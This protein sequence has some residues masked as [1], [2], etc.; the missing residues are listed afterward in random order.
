MPTVI[1]YLDDPDYARR[2]LCAATPDGDAGVAPGHGPIHWVLVA[3][4]PRMTHRISKWVSHSAREKWRDR[5]ADKVFSAT[6][7]WLAGADDRVTALVARG[8]LPEL[9]RHLQADHPGAHLVDARRPKAGV[10]LKPL[11]APVPAPAPTATRRPAGRGA[12]W[13]PGTAIGLFA[14]AMN[15]AIE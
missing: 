9:L 15:L 11:Q 2:Q 12:R 6:T 7:P 4:A 14:M 13:M 5:W 10:A 3:C 8:P 1:V